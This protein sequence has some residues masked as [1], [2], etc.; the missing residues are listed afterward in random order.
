MPDAVLLKPGKLTT[1][2]FEYIKSH[3]TLGANTLKEVFAEY[4]ENNFIRVGIEICKSHHENWD[5]TGYP[6]GIS[7]RMIPLS[8]RI[9]M[10]C[11]VYDALRSKRPYKDP[12]PHDETVNLMI[13]KMFNK[14]DPE[15][16]SEFSK[17]SGLFAATADEF[18]DD[19]EAA[20]IPAIHQQAK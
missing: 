10:V 7:G 12:M 13:G 16:L 3:T 1:E 14:F 17:I 20:I 9:L 8:A 11:D 2:E 19:R 6:E 18:S 15:V 5:G 4:P